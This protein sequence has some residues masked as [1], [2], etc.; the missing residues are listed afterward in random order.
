MRYLLLLTIL[1]VSFS[2]VSSRYIHIPPLISNLEE[3]GDYAV[4]GSIATSSGVRTLN[5]NAYYAISDHFVAHIG[6]T[7]SKDYVKDRFNAQGNVTNMALGYTNNN[8]NKTFYIENFLGYGFGNIRNTELQNADSFADFSFSNIYNQF[9]LNL[10][11]NDGG[12]KRE[13]YFSFHLPIRVEYVQLNSL[14]FTNYDI[15]EER[16][17]RDN[18]NLL[19]FTVSK[20]IHYNFKHF[21]LGLFVSYHSPT[22]GLEL[23]TAENA[24]IGFTANWRSFLKGKKKR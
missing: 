13:N 22:N 18:P 7:E 15:A 19:I 11:R 6:F 12:V 9:N 14:A 16:N 1:L 5:A 4:S 17:I 20:A 21:T 10:K 23:L 2:C 3:K 24:Y 8:K